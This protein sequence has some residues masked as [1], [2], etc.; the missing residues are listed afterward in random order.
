MSI[1]GGER[2]RYGEDQKHSSLGLE[3][4]ARE[5]AQHVAYIPNRR[6]LTGTAGILERDED[7]LKRMVIRQIE[8]KKKR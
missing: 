1:I 4:N 6:R 3:L 7:A 2:R 5:R 8:P